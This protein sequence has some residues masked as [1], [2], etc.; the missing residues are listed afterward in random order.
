MEEA[1]K[2]AQ[3]FDDMLDKKSNASAWGKS[4]ASNLSSSKNGKRKFNNFSKEDNGKKPKGA[5]GPLS[6][7]ELELAHQEKLCFQCLGSHE[8]KDCPQLK[9]NAP[10]KSKEKE[11]VLH[12]VQLL[13]LDACS[14][15]LVV[16]VCHQ[17]VQ[18]ECSSPWQLTFSTP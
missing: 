14:K 13:P 5:R 18:H 10:D 12:M 1:I 17:A 3:I 6:T 8:R 4:F 16:Q 9:G 11:K 15:Y 7:N 2:R